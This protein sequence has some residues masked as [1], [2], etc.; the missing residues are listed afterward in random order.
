MCAQLHLLLL[1]R[2]SN[3]CEWIL[4]QLQ[5]EGFTWRLLAPETEAELNAGLTPEPDVILGLD[6]LV[7]LPHGRVLD[8]L[9][10]R[11]LDIPLIV[12]CDAG[13]DA[14]AAASLEQGAAGFIFRDR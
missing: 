13:A 11:G 1:A 3:S 8:L 4:G 6:S 14:E 10:E 9:R 2:R 5:S 12:V 7:R